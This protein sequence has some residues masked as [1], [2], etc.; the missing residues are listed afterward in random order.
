[1]IT[2]LSCPVSE[3]TQFDYRFYDG[4]V[5]ERDILTRAYMRLIKHVN[6]IY[7][8]CILKISI[9]VDF[10]YPVLFRSVSR[11]SGRRTM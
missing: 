11:T 4:G 5:R 9:V 8:V 7:K 3:L 1:M 10:E 6:S 2:P